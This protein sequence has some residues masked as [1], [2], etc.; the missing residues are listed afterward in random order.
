MYDTPS[1]GSD[2]LWLLWKESIQNCKCCRADMAGGTDWRTDGQTDGRTDGRSETN[3]LRCIMNVKT[4]LTKAF[5][6]FDDDTIIIQI[7][8]ICLC[9][10]KE[11]SRT[12]QKYK[13]G[14]KEIFKHKNLHYLSIIMST[15]LLW[16]HNECDSISNHQPHDC[17]L[18]RLFRRRSTKTSKLRVTGLCGGN[19][20]GTGEFPAQMASN[21][22]NVSIW[23][24]HHDV[25]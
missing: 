23:W 7:H 21:V 9:A 25:S 11:I 5:F 19:S 6:Y 4:F 2:H 24:D 13:S 15:S 22:E 8:R 12:I 14:I 16:H 18:N 1:H 10:T 20:P 3:I 17:L